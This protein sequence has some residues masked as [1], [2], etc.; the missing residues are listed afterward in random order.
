MGIVKNKSS[1][2]IVFIGL[3]IMP[4]I[5]HA[6]VKWF[7]DNDVLSPAP[8]LLIDPAQLG[9]FTAII[10]IGLIL[11]HSI[12]QK[13]KKP[14]KSFKSFLKKIKKYEGT[15]FKVFQR[16]IGLS[17]VI[18]GLQYTLIAPHYQIEATTEFLRLTEIFV[19]I[20]MLLNIWIP[21]AAITLLILYIITGFSVGWSE[22]IDYINTAGIAIYLYL[23]TSKN[24]KISKDIRKKAFPILRISTGMALIILAFSE[25]LLN[26]EMSLQLLETTNFNFMSA[27][28]LTAF[29]DQMFTLFAGSIETLIGLIFI[30]GYI[31]RINTIF[32]GLF[33]L[34]SN[35]FLLL[36]NNIP[37]AWMELTGHLPIIATALIF[38]AHTNKKR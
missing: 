33:L 22:A 14:H 31:T 10:S 9:V 25:K 37:Q 21:G 5:S 28:G 27:I 36:S 24:K 32:F 3:F 23:T 19:G 12:D 2:L 7:V 13:F 11:A 38:L 8:S 20:L 18:N 35:L 4:Q 15:I 17:L 16:L 6:H 34:S 30:M 1:L 26:P 29:D